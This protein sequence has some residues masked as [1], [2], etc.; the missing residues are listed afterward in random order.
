MGNVECAHTSIIALF[1]D[2]IDRKMYCEFMKDNNKH[3]IYNI[4]IIGIGTI[5]TRLIGFIMIP[6]Y[7]SWLT[8]NEYGLYDLFA[9]YVTLCVPFVSLQLDQAIYRFSIVKKDCSSYYY[10]IIS[11]AIIPLSCALSLLVFI[12]MS[13]M[14]MERDII[15][16]FIFQF[17]AMTYYNI[18]SEYL[19]GNGKL[20][21]YSALNVSLGIFTI[22]LSV[23]FLKVLNLGVAGL[24][25]VYACAYGITFVIAQIIFKPLLVQKTDNTRVVDFLKYSI[26][27]IPNNIS[28]WI[29]NVSDRTLI[30]LIQGSYYNGIYAICCKIPTV[31][32]IIFGIFNLSFQQVA[33]ENIAPEERKLYFNQ[34]IKKVIR[35][36]FSGSAFI[37]GVTPNIYHLFLKES[38]WEGIPCIPVLLCGAIFLSIAQYMGG[39]LLVKK[40]TKA[41]G[42]STICAALVNIILNIFAIPG[43]GLLGASVATM[44]S[45]V[46]MFVIRAIANAEFFIAKE[47]FICI[48]TYMFL[49]IVLSVVSLKYMN[50]AI[51]SLMMAFV[52]FVIFV[53]LNKDLL[54][55]ILKK[56]GIIMVRRSSK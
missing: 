34:L 21:G 10:R 53:I 43:W 42:S 50:N 3:L 22:V 52:T 24:L 29:T 19:R 16:A 40:N 12:V 44:V 9:T 28:W 33:L 15:I 41:V 47:L 7:S 51:Y 37:V 18:I 25:L 13:Y 20:I 8:T 36:L 5:F 56:I 30:N 48:T 11:S 27:L 35:L 39:I 54:I 1:F 46:V 31:L 38:Y 2:Y 17:V 23:L 32:S 49:Y 55:T 26:P 14:D 45:Y 6:F 4:V